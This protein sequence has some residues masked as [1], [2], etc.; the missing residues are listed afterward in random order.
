MPFFLTKETSSVMEWDKH[1]SVNLRIENSKA[2]ATLLIASSSLFHLLPQAQ[3][4]HVGP[5]FLDVLET[6]GF[7]SGF[8]SIIP[9]ECIL[10]ISG[11][12]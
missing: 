9:A 12:N 6:L 7:G 2:L 5:N 10:A 11:P 3:R 8:P 4:T 1:R